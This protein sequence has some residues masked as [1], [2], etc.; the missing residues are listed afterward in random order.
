MDVFHCLEDVFKQLEFLN[1]DCVDPRESVCLR[2]SSD[3]KSFVFKDHA[4]SNS[5]LINSP[6]QGMGPTI[7]LG[8]TFN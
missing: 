5:K 3:H 6:K 4:I 1:W 2:S 7:K 8:F